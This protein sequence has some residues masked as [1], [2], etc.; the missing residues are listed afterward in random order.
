MKEGKKKKKPALQGPS[1]RVRIC[2]DNYKRIDSWDPSIFGACGNASK[3]G[4]LE[5]KE[6]Q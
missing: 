6:V 2:I 5:I 4:P 3:R 1:G